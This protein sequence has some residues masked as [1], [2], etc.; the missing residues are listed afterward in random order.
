M[1]SCIAAGEQ[2]HVT[3]VG[4]GICGSSVA[5]MLA[6]DGWQ[7]TLCAPAF[8][9]AGHFAAALTPVIS[10]DDNPRSRLSRLGAAMAGQFWRD[11]QANSPEPFGQ[12]CGALQLQRPEGAKRVQDLRRQATVLG[13]PDWAR[14]VERDEASALAGIGLP[15]GGI[16]YPEGWLL[17]VPK[18]IQAL[19]ATPGLALAARQIAR[20]QNT[21]SGWL[22]FDEAGDLVTQS[23]AVVLA[24]AFDALGLLERSQL[25]DTL[26]AC[27]RLKALHRLA[28]EVTLLPASALEGGPRCIVGGD[29]YVL[30][31]VDGWCVSGGTYVRGAE[32]AVCSE[33]GRPANIERASVL[34]GRDVR[35]DEP[36]NLP[37][38]AGWRAVLPGR[39]PAIGR[40]PNV[41]GLWVFT[42]AASRGLTWSVLGARLVSDGL[43]GRLGSGVLL[44]DAMWCAIR[45]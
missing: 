18:L 33:T 12:A 9:H 30:P 20:I 41:D 10:S 23:D 4:G 39:L 37:G 25:Y 2:G 15:R 1:D 42:A 36:A 21:T 27:E 44:D 31:S 24:N 11:L 40:L 13:Q 16:W 5:A 43:A 45:L 8:S 14:W 38:W 22:V 34:L 3:V 7:V 6:K 26:N 35:I 17:Q 29:G 19:Q 28:G 32:A